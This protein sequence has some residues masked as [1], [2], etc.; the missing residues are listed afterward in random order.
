[1]TLGNLTLLTSK[2]NAKVSNSAWASKKNSLQEHDVL[3][4]NTDLL[5]SA[6]DAWTEAKVRARTQ[7]MTAAIIEI[8][9]VPPGHT[10]GFGKAEDRPRRRVGLAD[11]IG[12]GLLEP[13]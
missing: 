13:G 12:A 10:S 4:M 11:L 8:W 1:H 2:L 3:K 5:A 7:E 9:P 6:G